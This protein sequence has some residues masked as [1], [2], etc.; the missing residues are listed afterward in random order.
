MY[1]YGVFTLSDAEDTESDGMAKRSQWHQWH[2]LSALWSVLHI[3]LEPITIVVGLGIV[4]GVVQCEK[5]I[6]DINLAV[7]VTSA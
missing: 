3:T 4:L 6:S 5:T 7:F 1:S 2:G